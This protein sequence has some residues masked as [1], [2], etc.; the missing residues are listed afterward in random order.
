[1]SR[2]PVAVPPLVPSSRAGIQ[3]PFQARRG[4]IRRDARRSRAPFRDDP[5]RRPS[6]G[7]SCRRHR[8]RAW[9]RPGT[10]PPGSAAVIVLDRDQPDGTSLARLRRAEKTASC[11]VRGSASAAPNDLRKTAPWSTGGR[12]RGVGKSARAV[13]AF[14]SPRCARQH[15]PAAQAGKRARHHREQP[16]L[17]GRRPPGPLV[18]EHR[19]R[20]GKQR[21]PRSPS[22]SQAPSVQSGST[23]EDRQ[24]RYAQPRGAG[25]CTASAKPPD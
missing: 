8:K 16:A 14:A 15:R 7:A 4:R 5:A 24:R 10:V 18:E 21:R 2:S 6:A 20:A 25:G 3:R 17:V 22:G 13:R 12:R 9:R 19:R 11:Q 1:M 23:V